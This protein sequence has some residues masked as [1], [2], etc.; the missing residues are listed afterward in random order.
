MPRGPGGPAGPLVQAESTWPRGPTGNESS[1]EEEQLPESEPAPRIVEKE[2]KQGNQ[3]SENEVGNQD[4]IEFEDEMDG[5]DGQ[6]NR[7]T[8][9]RGSRGTKGSTGSKGQKGPAVQQGERGAVG[10]ARPQVQEESTRTSEKETV[11]TSI[12]KLT[13]TVP[14]TLPGQTRQRAPAWSTT[15]EPGGRV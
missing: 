7:P 9:R 8:E 14:T 2:D 12:M 5:Q 3:K 4:E 10:T 6:H 1:S 11:E 13:Q 15:A